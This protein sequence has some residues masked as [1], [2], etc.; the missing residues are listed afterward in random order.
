MFK[1]YNGMALA[2]FLSE[3]GENWTGSQFESLLIFSKHDFSTLMGFPAVWIVHL[4]TGR[5]SHKDVMLIVL[6]D[7]SLAMQRMLNLDKVNS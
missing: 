7:L 5:T 4:V 1:H 3:S 2:P 6:V